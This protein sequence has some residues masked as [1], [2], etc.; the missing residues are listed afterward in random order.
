MSIIACSQ[1]EC[2]KPVIA[3]GFCHKHYGRW[4][5]QGDPSVVKTIHGATC[6]VEQC[7]RRAVSINFCNMHYKRLRRNGDP[8]KLAHRPDLS[9][10]YAGIHYRVK[11]LHGSASRYD[12]AHCGGAALD[13]AYDHK[14]ADEYMDHRG[15]PF[16]MKPE[17]YLPLC[18]SCH[19]TF[20]YLP[21]NRDSL[22]HNKGNQ[23][24]WL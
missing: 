10:S 2:D 11:S 6:K 14:D 9:P 13:W 17:H 4:R 16:S 19:R 5:R 8:V 22:A 15:R 12:C 3:R 18:R 24:T 1:E 23:I 20:D 7:G 21:E